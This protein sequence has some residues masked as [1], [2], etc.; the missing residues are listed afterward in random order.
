MP[1]EEE[2]RGKMRITELKRKDFQG[3]EL[4]VSCDSSC[5]YDLR[6]RGG[7]TMLTYELVKTPCPRRHL[8]WTERLFRSCWDDPRVYGVWD[9][10]TMAALMEVTPERERNR[11]RITSLYVDESYRRQGV[12]RMLVS[13]AM[14]MAREQRRRALVAEVRSGNW[15]ALSFGAEMG[16]KII[17]FDAAGYF[18]DGAQARSFPILLGRY[19]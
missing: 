15:G 4:V 14:D 5:C 2:R 3:F 17:G 12:G 6:E 11:L 9:N 19:L 16:M 7:G 8:E 18:N 1:R 13:R 10:A